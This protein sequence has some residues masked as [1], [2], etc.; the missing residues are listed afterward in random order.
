MEKRAKKNVNNIIM[1]LIIILVLILIFRNLDAQFDPNYWS[2]IEFIELSISPKYS[3]YYNLNIDGKTVK[4]RLEDINEIA[5]SKKLILEYR[6]DTSYLFILGLKHP[7]RRIQVMDKINVKFIKDIPHYT[8][9]MYEDCE[10]N[11]NSDQTI[12]AIIG[13][14]DDNQKNEKIFLSWN[15]SL[16]YFQ[17]ILQ[18]WK[19]DTVNDKIVEI[20]DNIQCFNAYYMDIPYEDDE[21][22]TISAIGIINDP[23]GYVNVREKPVANAEILYKLQLNQEFRYWEDKNYNWWQVEIYNSGRG[24]R[25]FGF[26]HKSRIKKK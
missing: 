10:L 3:D 19:V 9:I 2:N 23:D 18:A 21:I 25:I 26:V 22:D 17:N 6:N 13:I 20:H 15:Y 14:N 5:G 24:H 4:Y 16:Q 11:N 1:K 12:F 7:F 8:D